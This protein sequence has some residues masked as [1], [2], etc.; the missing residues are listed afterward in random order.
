MFSWAASDLPFGENNLYFN[1]RLGSAEQQ[2]NHELVPMRTF[3]NLRVPWWEDREWRR[4]VAWLDGIMSAD[5]RDRLE[6]T[7]S[8]DRLRAWRGVWQQQAAASNQS[9][10][11]LEQAHML[12]IVEADARF[13]VF[14]RG[15]M[16]DRGRVYIRQGPPDQIDT[17]A[18]DLAPDGRW[19]VWYYFGARM[20]YT[21]YDPQGIGDFH[22]YSSNAI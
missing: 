3:L 2:E 5:A 9:S 22:L 4:H 21:F 16:S 12:R 11:M 15:A 1:L 18:V 10:T 6:R 19:E 14:G 20:R 7:L 13:S 8:A 17:E